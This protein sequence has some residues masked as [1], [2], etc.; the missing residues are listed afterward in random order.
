M[1]LAD[2]TR[3]KVI[4]LDWETLTLEQRGLAADEIVRIAEGELWAHPRATIE[5]Q[6]GNRLV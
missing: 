3:A 6:V 1:V 5:F 4:H 2:G